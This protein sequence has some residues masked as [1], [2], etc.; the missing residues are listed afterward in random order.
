M[1]QIKIFSTKEKGERNQLV[2][3]IT[4]VILDNVSPQ[5]DSRITDFD[6][7]ESPQSLGWKGS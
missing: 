7:T 2:P 4:S 5:D 3:E 1:S 6:F